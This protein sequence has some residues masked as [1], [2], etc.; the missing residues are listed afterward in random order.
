M[1]EKIKDFLIN[2]RDEITYNLKCICGQPTPMKRFI[3]VLI[4]GGTLS[5]AFIYTLVSSIYNIGKCDAK[6]EFMEL[7]HI[8]TLKL[9]HKQDSINILIQ[10]EYEYEQ[11]DDR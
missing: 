8:E 6:K 2:V 7:Q 9:Q 1:K 11:S 4:I 5:I 3:I 10:K